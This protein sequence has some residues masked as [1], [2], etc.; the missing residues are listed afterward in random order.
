M[1]YDFVYNNYPLQFD[2][3]YEQ[4]TDTT[5]L[6]YSNVLQEKNDVKVYENESISC[7]LKLI[8]SQL[9]EIINNEKNNEDIKSWASKQSQ[10]MSVLTQEMYKYII[11][12]N[13]KTFIYSIYSY[14]F[15]DHEHI[16]EYKN[17]NFCG[18]FLKNL[19]HENELIEK[20]IDALKFTYPYYFSRI[21]KS[22]RNRT[23]EEEDKLNILLI[24]NTIYKELITFFEK[25]NC[26]CEPVANPVENTVHGG[27][28]KR[29]TRK[30]KKKRKSYKSK[31]YKA[32]R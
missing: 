5:R 6:R 9:N 27:Y 32:R 18:K 30:N 15:R 10:S 17:F 8:N 1:E 22:E 2:K 7:I 23:K 11:L 16:T 25:N 3:L 14:K 4:N 31:T 20:N 29:K 28:K 12:Y 26:K 19:K 21:Q 13:C 24:H